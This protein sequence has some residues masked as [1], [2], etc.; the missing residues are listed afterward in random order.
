MITFL[1][2][3]IYALGLVII[4][5]LPFANLTINEYLSAY[6]CLA[7]VGTFNFYIGTRL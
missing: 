3:I 6:L 5:M 2:F 1:Q 4:A 7:I